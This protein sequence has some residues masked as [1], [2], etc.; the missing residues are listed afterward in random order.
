MAQYGAFTTSHARTKMCRAIK[1]VENKLCDEMCSFRANGR[2]S[3]HTIYYMDTDSLK[4]LA[5][6][7]IDETALLSF[8][9]AFGYF[10][11]ETKDGYKFVSMLILGPK[12]YMECQVPL[13]VDGQN[14]SYNLKM[15]GIVTGNLAPTAETYAKFETMLRETTHYTAPS[16]QVCGRPRLE[17]A[18]GGGIF[19]RQ[20]ENGFEVFTTKLVTPTCEKRYLDQEHNLLIHRPTFPFGWVNPEWRRQ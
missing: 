6:K 17:R 12:C 13:N 4:M 20:D 1:N 9:K 5:Q 3:L 10:D 19:I 15:K 16:L 7:N 18:I 14:N 11:D 8:G 2:R